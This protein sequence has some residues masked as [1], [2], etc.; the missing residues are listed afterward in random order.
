LKQF[1]LL[2]VD[3]EAK[4]RRRRLNTALFIIQIIIIAFTAASFPLIKLASSYIN[5]RSEQLTADIANH[6]YSE[7]GR[8]TDE[9]S[10]LTEVNSAAAYL[11]DLLSPKPIN[12][13]WLAAINSTIPDE[14][15]LESFEIAGGCLT[16]A[17]LTAELSLVETHRLRLS[18]EGITATLGGVSSY[19]GKYRYML[20][21]NV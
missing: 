2:P 13:E 15:V 17:C 4:H 1:N 12:S 3:L 16:V 20:I 7:A 14:V 19:D 18:E 6:K 9:L 10:R 8:I 5:T 11:N 21:A